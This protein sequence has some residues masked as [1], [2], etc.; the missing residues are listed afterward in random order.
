MDLSGTGSVGNPDSSRSNFHQYQIFSY[1]LFSPK[2]IDHSIF[3][4]AIIYHQNHYPQISSR[5]AQHHMLRCPDII[6]PVSHKVTKYAV[7]PHKKLTLQLKM[8]STTQPDNEVTSRVCQK[9][10]SLC[11][12][13]SSPLLRQNT[14]NY[15][16]Q[17]Q[18][19]KSIFKQEE[20]QLNMNN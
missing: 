3:K 16:A 4:L 1:Q 5:L 18:A 17:K 10:H 7:P 12:T 15:S 6:Q 19:H 9:D 14:I 13:I 11:P 8:C 2:I 20:T